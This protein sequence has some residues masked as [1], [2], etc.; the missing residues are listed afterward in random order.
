VHHV[1]HPHLL[2][3][4]RVRLGREHRDRA[5]PGGGEDRA[6]K[7]GGRAPPTAAAGRAATVR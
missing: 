4:H 6:R 1:K 5:E 2:V 3:A 7:P